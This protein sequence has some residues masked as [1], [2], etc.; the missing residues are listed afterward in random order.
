MN[1]PRALAHVAPNLYGHLGTLSGESKEYFRA[2]V[3]AP[4]QGLTPYML[5]CS[6]G[7]LRSYLTV[8]RLHESIDLA[9][10]FLM[11]QEANALYM[12]DLG[13]C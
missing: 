4:Y 9:A 13:V 6:Y 10:Y 1:Q 2:F 8:L 5:M 3:N 7:D 11:V 12:Y